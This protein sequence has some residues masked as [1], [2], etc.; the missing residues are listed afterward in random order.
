MNNINQIIA[1]FLLAFCS[2]TTLFGQDCRIINKERIFVKG[3][4]AQLPDSIIIFEN[5]TA[6]NQNDSYSILEKK[7]SNHFK[8]TYW[9]MTLGGIVDPVLYK[10]DLILKQNGKGIKMKF[11]SLSAS[12]ECQ[13]LLI[14]EKRIIELI[15]TNNR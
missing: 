9:N 13:E 12:Y 14:D 6:F 2:T 4:I 8:I 7:D 5:E 3:E 1:I 11:G 15:K 10:D